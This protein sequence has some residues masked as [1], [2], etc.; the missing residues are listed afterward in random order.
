MCFGYPGLLGLSYIAFYAVGAY[1][2]SLLVVRLGFSFWAGLCSAFVVSA[3]VAY[4]IGMLTLRLKEDYFVIATLGI[5]L[6][7][8]CIFTNWVSV[9]GGPFGIY[10]IPRP[11]FFGFGLPSTWYLLVIVLVMVLLVIIASN[12]VH[13]PA[14]RV[15][16]A[17]REGEI[18]TRLLGKSTASFKILLFVISSGF[19]GI[20]GALYASLIGFIGPG[21]F[22]LWD[23]FIVVSMVVVGGK[24]TI[25]GPIIGAACLVLLPEIL[26]FIGLPSTVSGFVNQIIFGII[27]I[28]L[29][30]FRP[31]GLA[32]RRV[33]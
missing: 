19:A 3:L 7:V 15:L 10:G 20:A 18:V 17:I 12:I 31:H 28:F 22:T 8:I 33:K 21:S 13:S 23:M 29:I 1:A 2:S 30:R 32:G 6:I 26:R 16:R 5:H 24:G 14:G 11:S 4:V 27:V 25:K 9:T